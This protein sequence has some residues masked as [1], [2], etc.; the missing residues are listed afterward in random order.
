MLKGAKVVGFVAGRWPSS[1]RAAPQKR[2]FVLDTALLSESLLISILDA[3]A[4]C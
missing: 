4:T 1:I 2:P 3:L